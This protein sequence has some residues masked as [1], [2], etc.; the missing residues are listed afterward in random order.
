M[1]TALA[2]VNDGEALTAALDAHIVSE[3]KAA[4]KQANGEAEKLRNRLKP[5]EFVAKKIAEKF[6]LDL[7]SEE[8]EEKVEEVIGKIKSGKPT[9]EPGDSPEVKSRLKKLET[10][11]AAALQREESTRI[12][13][14]E[15]FKKSRLA[16][17]LDKVDDDV[18]DDY[19]DLLSIKGKV[20]DG[21]KLR[22]MK[23]EEEVTDEDFVKDF[24]AAKKTI[25]KNPG[26]PGA[27]AGAGKGGKNSEPDKSLDPAKAAP[28]DLLSAAFAQ[29]K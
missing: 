13:S 19:I 18:R 8:L 3:R 21:D 5:A 29:Q 2:A 26:Q 16:K 1:K 28:S 7:N 22:F 10:D 12:K 24:L 27:G 23:G 20:V 25:L 14:E 4:S 17:L 9:G 15:N 11:L 6:D